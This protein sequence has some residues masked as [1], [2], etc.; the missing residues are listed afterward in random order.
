LGRQLVDHGF[1][2]H[3]F[4]YI[5]G[6]KPASPRSTASSNTEAGADRH[7]NR[8]TYLSLTKQDLGRGVAAS[9]PSTIY[10]TARQHGVDLGLGLCKPWLGE[11]KNLRNPHGRRG[12]HKMQAGANKI[13]SGFTCI[14]AVCTEEHDRTWVMPSGCAQGAPPAGVEQ[15]RGLTAWLSTRELEPPLAD[16]AEQIQTENGEFNDRPGPG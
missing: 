14:A 13:N 15:F 8:A 12:N 4:C 3:V 2:Q 1:S 9:S 7:S 10:Y 5:H 11:E 6:H 16:E